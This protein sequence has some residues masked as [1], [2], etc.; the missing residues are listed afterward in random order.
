MTGGGGFSHQGQDADRRRGRGRG[1][2]VGP[3]RIRLKEV[4]DYSAASLHPFIADNLAPGAIAKTDG[5]SA[6]PGAPARQ[7]RS[8]V[9][10]KMA[11]H[12]VLPWV[13]CIFSN[14]KVWAL[15]AYHGLRRKHLPSYLDRVRLPLQPTP[16]PPRRLSLPARHRRRP[17]P[18]SYN[19]LDLT[20]RQRHKALRGNQFGISVVGLIPGRVILK[21]EIEDNG[22][23]GGHGALAR[24]VA[25]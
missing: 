15:G 16:P 8:H 14:L 22:W 25:L 18:F 9:I 4:P 10:G 21:G 1:R 19:M 20:G 5:W 3:G 23:I 24:Q 11:A 6:Y 13:H 2:R 12:I 7:T 17:P